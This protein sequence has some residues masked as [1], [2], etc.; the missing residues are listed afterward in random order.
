MS[1][2]PI[3]LTEE[4]E[5]RTHDALHKAHEEGGAF[6]FDE[7]FYHPS[8]DGEDGIG[9]LEDGQ[10]CLVLDRDKLTG[11]RMSLRDAALLGAALVQAGLNVAGH[12]LM[13]EEKERPK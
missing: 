12:A 8:E 3:D 10:V 7:Y 9:Y 4:R 11:V 2:K 1:N 13:P 6:A 5:K